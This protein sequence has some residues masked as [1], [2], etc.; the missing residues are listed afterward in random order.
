MVPICALIVVPLLSAHEFVP[1]FWAF[2]MK[3]YPLYTRAVGARI[4]FY[5]TSKIQF[6][7]NF[8]VFTRFGAI[9]ASGGLPA[10]TEA[11][12]VSSK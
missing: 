2:R 9:F 7:E 10:K 6:G 5:S 1:L 11:S 4:I 8:P 3:L 12:N